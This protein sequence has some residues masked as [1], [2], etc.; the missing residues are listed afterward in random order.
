METN[1][2]M[3]MFLDESREHLQS[4]NDG[5]LSLENDPEDLSVLNEIFR[6]AHTLKG[7]SATMGYTR[8][9]E[10]THDMENLLDFSDLVRQV[11]AIA[12]GESPAAP[13][14]APAE[15]T[16]ATEAPAEA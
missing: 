1:Q 10:L 3:E 2:Y 13:A 16:E 12:K 5:L 8:T 14:E 11:N 15:G 6:N 7:M 9:A 4:L